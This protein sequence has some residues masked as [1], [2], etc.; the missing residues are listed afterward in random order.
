MKDK[1]TAVDTL[2][3]LATVV[4]ELYKMSSDDAAI[5]IVSGLLWARRFPE[6]AEV[7]IDAILDATKR[8]GN[9]ASTMGIQAL[10]QVVTNL[11]RMFPIGVTITP[12]ERVFHWN[13]LT[14]YLQG[15]T[16]HDAPCE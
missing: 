2:S 1:I 7:C 6:H 14:A 15:L 3:P 8:D 13:R 11:V 12:E 9:Y 4:G 10:E 16:Q 5:G